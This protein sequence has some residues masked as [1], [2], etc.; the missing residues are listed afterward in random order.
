MS[1]SS[2]AAERRRI[3]CR[4]CGGSVDGKGLPHEFRL[5]AANGADGHAGEVLRLCRPCADDFPSA[6][7]RDAYLERLSA[8]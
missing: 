2:F 7:A 1:Q 5:E 3:S 8:A 6:E 4:R